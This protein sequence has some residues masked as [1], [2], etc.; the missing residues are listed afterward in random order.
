MQSQIFFSGLHVSVPTLVGETYA[1]RRVITETAREDEVVRRMAQKLS[2]ELRTKKGMSKESIHSMLTK[3][4]ML[5]SS[6][7][8]L[9]ALQAAAYEHFDTRTVAE[10]SAYAS[11]PATPSSQRALLSMDNETSWFFEVAR[12]CRDGYGGGGESNVSSPFPRQG[13]RSLSLLSSYPPH[14]GLR[15]QSRRRGS[16]YARRSVVGAHHQ[17]TEAAEGHLHH[18]ILLVPN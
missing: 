16:H 12:W 11:T 14:Y 8:M 7:E 1:Q 4:K 9:F 18:G 2:Y 10:M 17:Q 15:P 6:R 13:R 5:K 3:I